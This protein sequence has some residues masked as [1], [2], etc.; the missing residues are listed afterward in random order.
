MIDI[1]ERLEQVGIDTRKMIEEMPSS[2][3]SDEDRVF[4]D[5]WITVQ[6][7]AVKMY[8]A[9]SKSGDTLTDLQAMLVVSI[10]LLSAWEIEIKQFLEEAAK[11]E[12]N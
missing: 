8:L 4:L 7:D 11:Q 9:Q 10:H 2:T 6:G 1:K 3:V 5:Q 12:M